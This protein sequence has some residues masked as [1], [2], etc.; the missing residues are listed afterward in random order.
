M[1]VEWFRNTTWNESIQAAFDAKLRRARR[2]GQYLR[3]Q[4]CTLARSHPEI[5]LELLERY[6]ALPDD[7]DRAQA[8][9][10]RAMAFLLSTA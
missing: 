3:I 4:A 9:V 7:F 6:L 5:A 1:T 10:D 8:Y 2:K